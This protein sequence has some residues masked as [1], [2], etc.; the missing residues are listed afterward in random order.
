MSTTQPDE[1]PLLGEDGE[2]EVGVLVGEEVELVLRAL[3]EPVAEEP[4][5]A[6]RDAR[7]VRV[8][9]ASQDVRLGVRGT[10]VM[11]SLW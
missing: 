2:R 7:V 10:I 11:R 4:A 9:A 1:A 3:H 6:D 5:V 8:P